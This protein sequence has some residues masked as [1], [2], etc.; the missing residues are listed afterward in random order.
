[1]F[2]IRLF[3]SRG[4][5]LIVLLKER[6]SRTFSQELNEANYYQGPSSFDV[7]AM[8]AELE[9]LPKHSYDQGSII[10]FNNSISFEARIREVGAQ[11]KH[12]MLA[13]A[14]H[15]IRERIVH[16]M[17]VVCTLQEGDDFGKLALVN[18]SPRAATITL[19]EDQAQFLTVDKHDF[20]RFALFHI[21]NR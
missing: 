21:K 4:G 12:T 16:K 13:Q 6:E 17:G 3:N 19:R 20:N 7:S 15:L 2:R 5:T 14:P 8:Q 18:D 9:Q 10:E 1:M 11:L